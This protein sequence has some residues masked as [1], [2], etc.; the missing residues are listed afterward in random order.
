[1][2]LHQAIEKAMKNNRMLGV[3]KPRGIG[4]TTI[5]GCLANYF[6]R[7]VPGS[8]SFITSKDKKG[9]V[10]VFKEKIIPCYDAYDTEFLKAGIVNKNETKDSAY[11]N[12]E[13]KYLF[14]GEIRNAY[15]Q[16]I[17]E[18]TSEKPKSVTNFSGKGANYGFYDEFPL[19]PRR[20]E[21]IKS[22]IECYREP[23]TKKFTGFLLWGGTCEETL[24]NENIR[25]LYSA[26]SDA[27][28]WNTDILFIPFWWGMYLDEYG[29]PD[30]QKAFEWWEKEYEKF[31][32]MEDTSFLKA[33]IRN[34]PRTMDDIFESGGS[35]LFEEDVSEKIV[36]QISEI[37]KAGVKTEKAKI[38]STGDIITFPP[39]NEIEILEHPV[40]QAQYIITIDGVQSS[41]L[42]SSSPNSER[43]AMAAVVTKLY[44]PN[45]L[46]YMPVAIFKEIP[47]NL[48]ASMLKL[49][50]LM[51]Y[52]NKYGGLFKVNAERNVGFGEALLA[53][54]TKFNLQKFAARK[55][56][57][58]IHGFK[59]KKEFFYYRDD[60]VL[61]SQLIRANQFLRKY[62]SSVKMLPLL[63][64]MLKGRDD[65][66][67]I[68][69]AWLGLFETMPDIGNEK[70]KVAAIKKKVMTY[71][72]Y[73]NGKM[74]YKTKVAI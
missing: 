72:V 34:N 21:L 14:N 57:F 24:N 7:F 20:N 32:K 18:E 37:K 40:M 49:I 30:K 48:E 1:L 13:V 25:D 22:S 33:F 51:K 65:N 31:S 19:H 68:L 2:W 36:L 55:K 61:E 47:K 26:V 12:L 23:E 8:N 10:T 45:T 73:E 15:S 41:E 29:Y 64:D 39:G 53:L 60:K 56:D 17:C 59:D 28:L 16:I 35:G 4:L 67:D 43:S 9:V 58:S 50:D 69:D 38:V 6:A 27:E 11:L 62:I 63:E 3:I 46:P 42:T 52:Y 5:G 70:K 71:F 44:D 54:M 66:T 74:V